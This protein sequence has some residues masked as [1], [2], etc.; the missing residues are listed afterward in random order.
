MTTDLY[1]ATCEG[2]YADLHKNIHRQVRGEVRQGQEMVRAVA[3]AVAALTLV[4]TML[5]LGGA[6]D[7]PW[8]W[9]TIPLWASVLALIA[10]WV[11]FIVVFGAAML[12]READIEAS[13]KRSDPRDD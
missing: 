7:W 13:T 9:V 12:R 4:L 2:G 6:I 1:R 10:S 8:F 3:A 11:L 5:R